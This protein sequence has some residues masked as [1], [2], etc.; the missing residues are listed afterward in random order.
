MSLINFLFNKS[1]LFQKFQIPQRKFLKFA[2]RIERGYHPEVQ[3]H[4]SIHAADVLHGTTWLKDRCSSKVT[5]TDLELMSMY[6]AALIHDFEYS[7]FT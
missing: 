3:Y 6:V 2:S 5:P 7:D 1:D 4:N